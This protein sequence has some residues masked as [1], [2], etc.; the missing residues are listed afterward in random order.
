MKKFNATKMMALLMALCLITSTFVGSTL[1]KY[2]TQA[3]GADTA[4]VAKFGVELTAISDIFAPSYDDGAISVKSDDDKDVVAPGTTA[5]ATVFTIAGAPEV[6]V[7][8]DITLDADTS[9]PLSMVTLPAGTYTDWT[10]ADT[11]DT[12]TTT[13][14]WNPVVW[15]LTKAG[16]A[17]PLATGNLEDIETYLTG[18]LSGKYEVEAAAD[19]A[20]NFAAVVGTYTLTWDWA[21]DDATDAQKDQKDT[22]LGQIAAG[23]DTATANLNETFNFNIKVT[24]ID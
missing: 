12:Y 20:N 5:N 2:T 4:R 15:T 13:A 6:D 11:A 3:E 14:D 16:E 10:T 7:Q 8:V 1:A 18:T 17:A 24:Q 19:A 21:F 9:N 23:V 22:T